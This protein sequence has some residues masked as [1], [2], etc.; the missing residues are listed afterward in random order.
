MEEGGRAGVSRPATAHTS[1]TDVTVGS[2]A[3]ILPRGDRHGDRHGDGSNNHG[4]NAERAA[5]SS[6]ISAAPE[7][8]VVQDVEEGG[9]R[10]VPTRRFDS[11]SLQVWVRPFVVVG[12]VIW[13]FLKGPA[14]PQK[15][16]IKPFF[17]RFQSAP[18]RLLLRFAPKPHQRRIIQFVFWAVWIALF[19]I[20]IHW[21]R[22]RTNVGG[23]HLNT[24]G[25]GVEQLKCI[26][27][28]W[29]RNNDCGLNGQD[30]RPFKGSAAIPFRCPSGCLYSSHVLNTRQVG[31]ESLI[32]QPM[33][34]GGPSPDSP[35]DEPVYDAPYRS[36]TFICAA[37]IHSGITTN[38]FGGC[39]LLLQTGEYT[40]YSGSTRHKITSAG[41]DSSFPSSFV[42]VRPKPGTDISGCLDLRWHLLPI[43]SVFTLIQA[44]FSTNA[45]TLAGTTFVSTFWHVG[46]ASDTPPPSSNRNDF[47]EVVSTIVGRFLP[48]AFIMYVFYIHFLGPTWATNTTS[49]FP[50]KENEPRPPFRLPV[51]ITVERAVLLLL[52]WWFGALNNITFAA[53]IP[54]AR[55]TPQ[56]LSQPGA[57]PA[58][59]IIATVLVLVALGQIWF[60]RKEGR[61]L[62]YLGLYL[63]FGAAILVLILNLTEMAIRLHH[64][65]LAM[66]LIP[67]TKLGTRL[68][69]LYQGLL[70]GL[71]VNGAA[72]WG[73]A[74]FLE[75]RGHLLGDGLY[76]SGMV[77]DLL[78]PVGDGAGWRWN[79]TMA[80]WKGN[81]GAGLELMNTTDSNFT[82]TDDIGDGEWWYQNVTIRWRWP[83]PE[84][85]RLYDSKT[86]KVLEG[87]HEWDGVSLLLN[88]VERHR[89]AIPEELLNPPTTP[90]PVPP[91][92]IPEGTR[93]DKD[94][95]GG[96]GGGGEGGI[97]PPGMHLG[98]FTWTRRSLDREGKRWERL[99]IRIAYST[100]RNDR[101]VGDYTR[102]GVV[103][104]LW[105]M[106]EGEEAWAPPKLGRT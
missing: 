42:F 65:I 81:W 21:S 90:P 62:R 68:S 104:S 98:E 7:G 40:G 43:S 55:L 25:T 85:N 59:G 28:L 67:G 105:P 33:V 6:S 41:F 83:N 26:S 89:E 29:R 48:A 13:N 72:R 36:D 12:S 35:S 106:G 8:A 39:G 3:P 80:D 27:S 79:E 70:M 71:F 18:A 93:T 4:D 37:A 63:S 45:A 1:S 46:L 88:D 31:N 58:L 64:Y 20:I 50:T 77:P 99:Y 78:P 95:S 60:F 76:G 69:M 5:G 73:Y 74:S 82:A 61:L 96:G 100:A 30:C 9:H 53:L 22:F 57:K 16:F 101:G 14:P 56:D 44:L 66:L 84:E 38:T 17:P 49:T 92:N 24:D 32:Y 2:T 15:T 34:V 11:A 97:L 51:S 10:P 102:A 23:V 86:G 54:I 75:T 103:G 47:L 91:P 19:S 52:G 87:S 94:G